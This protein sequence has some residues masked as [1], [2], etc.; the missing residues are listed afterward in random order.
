MKAG[1]SR[2]LLRTA[3]FALCVA[4]AL[5]AAFA[6]GWLARGRRGPLTPERMREIREQGPTP[7]RWIN[8]LL[9]CEQAEEV[10]QRP[11]LV[12][13][14]HRLAALVDIRRTAGEI[15][16][17]S[18]YFRELHD[19][20][21]IGVNERVG[22]IPA[23]LLKLPTL[24]AVLKRAERDPGFLSQ[25]VVFPGINDKNA[26]IA[27]RPPQTLEP[28]E[29]YTVEELCRRMSRYS[30][31]NATGLL[32]ELVTPEEQNRTLRGLGVLPELIETRGKL[33]VKT[34]SAFFRVLYNASYI[35]RE[36]S[37]LALEMLSQAWFRDGII[38][39]LPE[40]V[41]VCSKYGEAALR[42]DT[43][44][45]HDFAIVYHKR[46]PYL[47]GVMTEGRDLVAMARFIREV[48]GLVY[49]EIDRQSSFGDA[50]GEDFPGGP[51]RSADGRPGGG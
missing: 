14:K 18:V 25:R 50:A 35:D 12:S 21:W 10:I 24:I 11:E 34:V 17:G 51:P 31:N 4:A 33:D 19:G 42:L 48:S 47:L 26:W 49:E 28:G 30:D 5:G 6:A 43:F 8:P 7:W 41:P 9:E 36:H 32:N 39:G 40:G 2:R 27:F 45:L 3:A 37:E 23:S 22:Y 1:A 20:R 46:R 13:F 15:A 16:F 29:S 38:G 44:Q